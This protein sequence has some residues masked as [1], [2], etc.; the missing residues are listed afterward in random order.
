[1]VEAR[2]PGVP[3]AIELLLED[4]DEG[5]RLDRVLAQRLPDFSRVQIQRWI[6]SGRVELD[7]EVVSPKS[8]ARA[9]AQVVVHPEAPPP[10]DAKAENIPLDILHEDGAVLVINKPAGLVVHP[11]PGHPSGTL[12]NAVL[13][14]LQVGGA[15]MGARPGIVHRLDKDTSGVM[16]VAKTEQAHEFLVEQ[17]Q[18]HA[19]EREYRAIVLGAFERAHTFDTLHGRH[20]GNRKKFTARLSRGKRAVTHVEP[21]ELLH[22]AS[23][24]RCRLETGRTHQIRVHL[25]EAGHPLLGDPM[26]GRASKDE[27]L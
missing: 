24:V 3:A 2:P 5:A 1:M 21:L 25:S 22:G 10:S 7:G 8:K 14:H 9:G 15:G 4:D 16:V 13:H 12:V 6:A 19:I 17:F 23:L 26:Y 11:A 18:V 27:R 20:P